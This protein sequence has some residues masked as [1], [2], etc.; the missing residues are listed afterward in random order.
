[1]K[2]GRSNLLYFQIKERIKKDFG[3]LESGERIP[4]RVELTK[5]YSATR[6]TIDRAISELIGEGFLYTVDGSGTYLA[7]RTESSDAEYTSGVTNWGVIL[8]NIMHDTYPG[9]LRGIEDVANENDVNVVI[10]NTDNYADKQRDYVYKLIESG[11]RG[12]IIVP[13]IIGK[14]TLEEFSELKKHGIPLVT[15][16]RIIE[17]IEAP[18]VLSNNFY[19]GYLATRHLIEQGYKRIAYLSRPMYSVSLDRYQ[20]YLGA[21]SEHSK[22]IIQ[23]SGKKCVVFEDSFEIDR[24]GYHSMGS[25]LELESPPDAVF[26]FNDAI[27]A[28]AY[29]LLTER[30]V[31]IGEDVGL[32]GYDNTSI[33][34]RLSPK[35]TSV[36]FKT[37]EIG[38]SAAK[39]L[40]RLSSGEGELNR[41]RVI[42]QPELVVRESSE[43]AKIDIHIS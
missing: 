3:G 21:L 15:C 13:A 25:L 7:D 31:R 33:C 36:R 23:E 16:N 1:M 12:L 10:C 26:C 42:L 18:S 30:G 41:K 32:V 38:S 27:A 11:V 4:S 37:Y 34:E 28:G 20:G 35:L 17:G 19:G 6:T 8:P 9:I 14:T 2:S 5:K 29:E 22:G 39:L 24:P 40:L 43:K